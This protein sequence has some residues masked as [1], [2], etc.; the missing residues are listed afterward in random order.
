M[1]TGDSEEYPKLG[2][3]ELQ[4]RVYNIIDLPAIII[5]EEHVLY[6]Y[7]SVEEIESYLTDFSSLGDGVIRL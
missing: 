7:N 1:R 2:A 6:G 4:M 5:N 3:V